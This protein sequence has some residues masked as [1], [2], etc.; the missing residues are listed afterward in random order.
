MT[1]T[2]VSGESSVKELLFSCASL[3]VFLKFYLSE[4]YI[5]QFTCYI[6]RSR[7]RVESN[8][9]S[10][11]LGY[12]RWANQ[13]LNQSREERKKTTTCAVEARMT[14]IRTRDPRART[15][16]C[17]PLRYIFY[18]LLNSTWVFGTV[19]RDLLCLERTFFLHYFHPSSNI[20]GSGLRTWGA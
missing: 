19:F 6:S 4:L 9:Y 16:T 5:S 15:L 3:T 12:E 14:E 2:W 10:W 20:K 11:A 1:I 18:P 7:C 17:Q 8:R 13:S